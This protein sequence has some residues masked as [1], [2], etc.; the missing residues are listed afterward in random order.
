MLLPIISRKITTGDEL[1]MY[2]LSYYFIDM[3]VLTPAAVLTLITGLIY[4]LF[5]NWGF[6]RHGWLIYKWAVTLLI[7]LTG[8]FYLG[9]LVTKSLGI[10]TVKR[11]ASLQDPNYIYAEIVGLYA[12]IINSALLI[13]AVCVSVYKPFKNIDKLNN[14]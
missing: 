3:F 10:A 4:S 7:I 9:P 6:F 1:Y 12:A 2:N 14:A 13:I 5:T 11:L 8:T